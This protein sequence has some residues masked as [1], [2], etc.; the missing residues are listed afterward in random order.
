MTRRCI[1]HIGMNKAG[2]TSLQDAYQDYDDG[3]TYYLPLQA[4]NHSAMMRM[5]FSKAAPKRFFYSDDA[6]ARKDQTV[7][8]R[9]QLEDALAADRRSVIISGEGMSSLKEPGSVSSVVSFLRARYDQVE[10]LCYVRDPAGYIASL[11]QQV[12]KTGAPSFNLDQLFPKYQT[13]LTDWRDEL[14]PDGL[15]FVAFHPD[16]LAGGDLLADFSARLHLSPLTE[17]RKPVRKNSSLSAEA[18]AVLFRYRNAK[19]PPKIRGP[20][21]E[22]SRRLIRLL[23]SFG[24]WKLVLDQEEVARLSVKFKAELDWMQDHTEGQIVRQS[25][26]LAAGSI[27]IA[28]EKQLLMLADNSTPALREWVATLHPKAGKLPQGTVELLDFL[29]QRELDPRSRIKRN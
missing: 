11:F 28:T 1:L 17:D 26:G 19:G 27:A 12:L 21:K 23:Q 29:Y 16:S 20:E 14:G 5:I 25:E 6:G 2:S 10:G 3:Q 24:R 13:R 8:L 15:R 18:V 7:A 9:Q 22:A 4:P